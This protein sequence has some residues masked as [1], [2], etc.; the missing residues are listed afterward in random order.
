MRN[1]I[2]LVPQ[3]SILFTGSILENLSWGDT[4]A[5]VDELE[6]AAKK[7]QIHE[8]IDLF[9]Q[10]YGTRVGQKGVNLSGGQKQRLSIARALVRKPSILIFDDST[11][12]LDVKTETALWDALEKEEATMLVVTQKISTARG[13]D[14]ILLL[15]E[16]NVVGYG[17][18][19][20]LLKQSALYRKIVE[21]Q[22]EEE[23][24][25]M[26]RAIRK[27]FG[28]EPILTKEDIKGHSKKKRSGQVT[29]NQFFTVFG[30]LLMSNVHFDYGTRTCFRQFGLA[31]FGPVLSGK[32]I[33]HHIITESLKDLA[34]KIGV[35][36]AIY[37]G[38]SFSM[39]F[40]SFWMAGV[41]QQTVYRLRT[42]LFAHLQKLPV[43]FFDK[44]QHGELMSRLTND[45][46][47]VSQTLN[48]SFIQVF[49]SILTL[50]GTV[51]VMLYLSPLLTLLTMIIVPMMFIAIRWITR[52]TGKLFKEQQQA[53]G[54]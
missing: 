18:H 11:S 10:K 32:I 3:Q 53:L 28:Y 54:N 19:N 33:D 1:T 45:I 8:S 12:A 14:K 22:S 24:E 4:E 39:Y 31:L 20:E 37:V 16:G 5:H 41:A 17:T 44:R 29:G 26:F 2:G 9:P 15:D 6:E 40:Q 23:V 7:A 52:R 25:P 38:L 42:N 43:T 46:E 49:S 27:P 30:S 35:L 50:T 48:T 36:I 13:A 34:C 21:S 51:A 47:N